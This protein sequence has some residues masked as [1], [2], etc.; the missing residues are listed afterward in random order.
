[1]P[2]AIT[3]SVP[4]SIVRCQLTHLARE[5]IDV[6]RARAQH[7][8]YEA[9]LAAAGYEIR[10]LPSA[11]EL[12]DSVFVEDTAIA[13][14]EVGII[15]RPGAESRRAEAASMA[16]ELARYRPLQFIT[17][18]GSVD[19]GDVL[20]LGRTLWVGLSRRSN[21]AGAAQLRALTVPLDYDVRTLDVGA[22]L[23]LK[24]AV[25]Q[26]KADTLL[27][28]RDWVDVRVLGDWRVI[29]VDPAEP[30][31]ANALWLDPVRDAVVFSTAFP[32]TADRLTAA[33]VRVIPV[34]ASELAKAEGGV[35][36]CSVLLPG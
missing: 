34:D 2:I 27:A 31:A 17:E 28:N 29:D 5:P 11:D 20:R 4:S 3:R 22:A 9:A 24:T 13:L 33:G 10:R 14:D 23:H 8:E 35:T 12:P 26:V 30:L 36:C 7:A 6:A 18:P 32:R 15:M 25:T 16:H 1:M 21:A 19:G